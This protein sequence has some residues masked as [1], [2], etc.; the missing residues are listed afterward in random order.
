M[1]RQPTQQ[2]MDD[3]IHLITKAR[4]KSLMG[5]SES[6]EYFA[7]QALNKADALK[8]TLFPPKKEANY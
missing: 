6:A 3:L 8:H 1:T 2:D 4:D 7:S 5:Y